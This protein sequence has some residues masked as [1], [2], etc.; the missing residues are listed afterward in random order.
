MRRPYR[1]RFAHG[2][3]GLD[4]CLA[5]KFLPAEMA[6]HPDALERFRR[7][8]RAASALN[9]PN[10]RTIYGIDEFEGHPFIAMET[11]DGRK[12]AFGAVVSNANAW[13]IPKLPK[14]RRG[15]VLR[16][17]ARCRL[18]VPGRGCPPRIRQALGR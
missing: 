14:P 12:V 6:S 18:A 13:A 16:R 10:I 17:L 8:A 7:D 2:G 11:L 4:S 3:G 5:L 15:S 1:R 9:H